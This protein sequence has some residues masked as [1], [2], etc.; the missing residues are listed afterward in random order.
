MRPRRARLGCVAWQGA[1]PSSQL[2]FNE[3]E[4]RAPRM[5]R[6]K[7]DAWCW[8][9]CFNEAEARAPRMQRRVAGEHQTLGASMRPRRARLGCFDWLRWMLR[10]VRASMRPRRARLGCLVSVEIALITSSAASMRPRRARL[11]CQGTLGT[12]LNHHDNLVGA[13][14]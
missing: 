5:R 2:S 4:A 1:C 13:Q 3:A 10:V 12:S 9:G 11:G 7:P 6:P 8:C 14:P